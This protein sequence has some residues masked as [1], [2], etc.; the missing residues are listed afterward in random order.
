MAIR[1]RHPYNI[2]NEFDRVFSEM[3]NRFAQLTG[4]TGPGRMYSRIMPALREEFRVDVREHEDEVIVVADLP[5]VDKEGISLNLT[6][7]QVLSLS[8]EKKAETVEEEQDFYMRERSY[9]SMRREIF[10]PAEVTHEGAVASFKNGV[11]EVKLKKETVEKGPGI[12]I[13]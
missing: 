6:N 12:P 8:C 3:E 1:R 5:G 11:L 13:E 9:G 7:P 10:L 4:E 2:W